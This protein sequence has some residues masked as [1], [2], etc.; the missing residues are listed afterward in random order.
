MQADV[1]DDTT[2]VLVVSSEMLYFYFSNGLVLKY[3]L[4]YLKIKF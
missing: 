1:W 2:N 3:G 4:K